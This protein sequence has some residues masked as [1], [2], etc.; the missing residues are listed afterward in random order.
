MTGA[1]GCTL[2]LLL[3]SIEPTA[4]AE[5]EEATRIE[6]GRAAGGMPAGS[7]IGWAM[8]FANHLDRAAALITDLSAFERIV[9]HGLPPVEMPVDASSFDVA[10]TVRTPNPADST[11]LLDVAAEVSGALGPL[12]DPARSAAVLGA[13]HVVVDGSGSVEFFYCIARKQQLSHDAFSDFWL[14]AFTAHSRHTPGKAGY[15]QVHADVALTAASA[16]AAGVGL[17][18]FD[19]IAIEWFPDLDAFL[20][21]DAHGRAKSGPG[22][23]FMDGERSMN[24]FARALS[25][26]GF[27]A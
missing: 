7:S 5:L 22:A 17:D 24:D 26:L 6:A 23:A 21:A 14:N 15:H 1:P 10:L 4:I 20:Q 25:M 3:R 16:R 18:D 9:K 27:S 19:G 12:V 2:V 8:N 13:E 11:L